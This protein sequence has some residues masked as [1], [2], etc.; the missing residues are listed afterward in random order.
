MTHR[1]AHQQAQL[2]QAIATAK[3]GQQAGVIAMRSFCQEI[4]NQLVVKIV[5]GTDQFQIKRHTAL[6]GSLLQYTSTKTVNGGHRR[7]VDFG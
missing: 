7:L 2:P 1:F 5:N 4:V 6:K 3:Q